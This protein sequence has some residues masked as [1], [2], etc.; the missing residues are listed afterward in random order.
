MIFS[1]EGEEGLEPDWQRVLDLGVTQSARRRG[2]VVSLLLRVRNSSA[3]PALATRVVD[4]LVGVVR[5]LATSRRCS[6]GRVVTCTFPLI[7][8]HAS[9]S[10]TLRL[11]V[12]RG[13]ASTVTVRGPVVD[14]DTADNTSRLRLS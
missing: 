7:A 9:V 13:L 6:G 3:A 12:R 5:V 10:V 1:R 2:R 11:R 14:A 4:R 8:P